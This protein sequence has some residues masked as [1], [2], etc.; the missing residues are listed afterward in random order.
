M[1][2]CKRNLENFFFEKKENFCDFRAQKKV[3]QKTNEETV[4]EEL[5]KDGKKKKNF[6]RH[7]Q[8]QE[9]EEE[10]RKSRE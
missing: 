2:A 3:P 7:A 9:K 4:R 1:Y 8:H 6:H 5:G 10:L